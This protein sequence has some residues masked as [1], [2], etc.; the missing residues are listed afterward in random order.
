MIKGKLSV[1]KM[2]IKSVLKV[3]LPSV[4][5]KFLRRMQAQFTPSEQRFRGMSKKV[6]FDT[7]YQEK[8]WGEDNQGNGTSGSG[9][10]DPEVIEP[11]VIAVR[12]FLESG[13]CKTIVDLGC[14]DFNVGKHFVGLTPNY[15]ACDVSDVILD[16]VRANSDYHAVEF[17]NLDLSKD[18]L[19][20]GDLGIV[21]QVLQHLS[22]ADIQYFVEH[23]NRMRP[24]RFLLLTE[25]LPVGDNFKVNKDKP[26][27]SSTRVA[28]N[29]GVFLHERP[30]SLHYK[31]YRVLCE[32]PKET[33]GKAAV[34]RSTLYEL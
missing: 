24:Y 16:Q 32:V 3:L 9:S 28:L 26:V 34:I 11:Y 14:G 25:H 20:H 17:V 1:I 2:S 4:L 21:R 22:N 5:R 7:I 6:V 13:F 31:S 23:L 29:S 30:F 33:F 15:I 10:S 12:K 18:L 27:G 19:P 8:I